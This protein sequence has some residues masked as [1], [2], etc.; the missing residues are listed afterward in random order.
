MNCAFN[1]AW[2]LKQVIFIYFQGVIIFVTGKRKMMIMFAV[3]A[4]IIVAVPITFVELDTSRLP[5]ITINSEM[6]NASYTWS[7]NFSCQYGKWD[8]QCMKAS[9]TI[10]EKGYSNSTFSFV[11]LTAIDY[12][13]TGNFNQISNYLYIQGRLAPNLGPSSV[14]VIG[15]YSVPKNMR[16]LPLLIGGPQPGLPPEYGPAFLSQCKNYGSFPYEYIKNDTAGNV[17][18]NVECQLQGANLLQV[19]HTCT[20]T[21]TNQTG[22]K[23]NASYRFSF[24]AFDHYYIYPESGPNP[25][26]YLSSSEPFTIHLRV[27]L[28]GLSKPVTL[29]IS[30]NLEDVPS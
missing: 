7:T 24:V 25:Y 12:I 26:S 9:A 17:S 28:M 2:Y 5:P 29:E 8:L 10:S 14:Q 23:S 6:A 22:I 20:Y 4:V 15:N 18:E 19:N 1:R 11:R 21:L 13:R 30:L 27:S 16:N 3:I